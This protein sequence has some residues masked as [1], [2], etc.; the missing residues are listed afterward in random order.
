MVVLKAISTTL[1]SI[2]FLISITHNYFENYFYFKKK[3]YK[4]CEPRY[5]KLMFYHS[6]VNMIMTP[7]LLAMLCYI[8]ITNISKFIIIIHCAW[9]L[10]FLVFLG[11]SSKSLK[12]M[13]IDIIF[14]VQYKE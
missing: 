8:M 9:I 4:Y 3:M 14:Y 10:H 1:C 7:V 6:L 11:D 13:I 12:S 2:A 5:C